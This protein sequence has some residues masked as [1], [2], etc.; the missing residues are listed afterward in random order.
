[1]V[2]GRK[3]LCSLIG[4]LPPDESFE[5]IPEYLFDPYVASAKL[6]K[7]EYC[8]VN[9]GQSSSIKGLRVVLYA[10]AA[11]A[12]RLDA[13]IQIRLAAKKFGWDESLMYQEGSLLGYSEPENDAWIE[14]LRHRRK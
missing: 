3:P 2:S 11:E 4:S 13:Y 6:V 9:S 10:L 14:A 12:W 7:R 1:M 5:E 8:E